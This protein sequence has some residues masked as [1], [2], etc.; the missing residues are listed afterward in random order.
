MT[1]ANDDD[2][3]KATKIME[4]IPAANTNDAKEGNIVRFM[5]NMGEGT[6]YWFQGTIEKRLTKYK[7]ARDCKFAKTFFRIVS[8]IV[9]SYWGEEQ[10][11]LPETVRCNLTPNA[12]WSV[13]TDVLL[14]ALTDDDLALEIKPCDIPDSKKEGDVDH[15]DEDDAPGVCNQAAI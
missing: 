9:I 15:E 5:H 1:E 2:E 11:L 8:L 14:P 3:V 12:A 6:V 7:I 4:F 13:G 10:K